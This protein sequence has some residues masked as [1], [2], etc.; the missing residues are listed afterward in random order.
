MTTD[1]Q[2]YRLKH[3]LKKNNKLIPEDL[4]FVKYVQKLEK[5]KKLDKNVTESLIFFAAE[6]VSEESS[7]KKLNYFI[8]KLS[9]DS[10]TVVDGYT[11]IKKY[12][13]GKERV[14]LLKSFLL[15]IFP[16]SELDVERIKYDFESIVC[17]NGITYFGE[18]NGV[19][20]Y[21]AS[22]AT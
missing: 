14:S 22:R 9:A 8:E 7:M 12:P 19:I 10:K 5:M 6:L 2:A 3:I 21:Q 1:F 4:Q 18:E 17:F 15:N 16:N 20:L 13:K 11:K